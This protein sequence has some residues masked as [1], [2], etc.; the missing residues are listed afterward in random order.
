MGDDVNDLEAMKIAGLSAAPAD[1][2]PA[3]LTTAKMVVSRNGGNGAVREL[4]DAILLAKS[5]V[6]RA[7]VG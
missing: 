6:A 1:A 7:E 2:V 4:V 5:T 3:V